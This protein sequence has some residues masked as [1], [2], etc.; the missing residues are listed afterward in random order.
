MSMLTVID[1][2]KNKHEL[3]GRL[4]LLVQAIVENAGEIVKPQRAQIVFDCAGG[5][6]DASIKHAL[7]TNRPEP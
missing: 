3:S 6:V 2:T 5:R 1:S 7:E 4:E